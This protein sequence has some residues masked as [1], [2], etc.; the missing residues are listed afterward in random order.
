MTD[1]LGDQA[2]VVIWERKHPSAALLSYIDAGAAL[3]YPCADS[4]F[5]SS[6]DVCEHY[7]IIDG[8]WQEAGK[9]YNRSPYLHDIPAVK[10]G[11]EGDS[12]YHLRRN[13][14]PGCLCTAECVIAAL[15]ARGFE[16]D[17]N[18]LQAEFGRFLDRMS[19]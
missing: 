1:V 4:Q 11:V 10:V 8:T 12:V 15:T 6:T 16:S 7:I 13:Q 19:V 18:R 3:L 9:I 14:K 2:E 5:I 17:A